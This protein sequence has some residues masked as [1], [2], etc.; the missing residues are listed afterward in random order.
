MFCSKPLMV[1]LTCTVWGCLVPGCFNE[2]RLLQN[3]RRQASLSL[4]EEVPLGEFRLT[5]PRAENSSNVLMVAIH[6]IANVAKKDVKALQEQ[7]VEREYE[8][9]HKTILAVRQSSISELAEPDLMTLRQRVAEIAAAT[10]DSVEI[11]SIV[12]DRFEVFAQ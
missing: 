11:Q 3:A 8:L 9:R 10:L 5:L 1:I 4:L 6:P 7:L 12:F 2:T